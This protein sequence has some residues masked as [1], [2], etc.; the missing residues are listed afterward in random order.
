MVVAGGVDGCIY[1][2]CCRT[3]KSVKS[4]KALSKQITSLAFHPTKPYVL[5]SSYDY[6][7]KLLDWENGWNFTIKFKEEHSDSVLQVVFNPEDAQDFASVS[8][9]GKIKVCI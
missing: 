3:M 4:F 5:L 2:Y 1:V 6:L 8:K 9:D 7:I